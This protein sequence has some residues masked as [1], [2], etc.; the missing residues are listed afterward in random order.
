M[1]AWGW[2]RECRWLS[3]SFE[4][5]FLRLVGLPNQ[6][7]TFYSVVICIQLLFLSGYDCFKRKTQIVEGTFWSDGSVLKLDG[8]DE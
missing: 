1:V 7:Q 4:I 5:E 6:Q 3:S 2:G 8:G